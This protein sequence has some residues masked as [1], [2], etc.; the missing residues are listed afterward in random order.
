MNAMSAV[1]A[2]NASSAATAINVPMTWGKILNEI[3]YGMG[4]VLDEEVATQA[5]FDKDDRE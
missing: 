2:L 4:E 5:V 3:N 1:D